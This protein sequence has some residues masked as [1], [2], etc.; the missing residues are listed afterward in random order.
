MIVS[1]KVLEGITE[2]NKKVAMARSF[3]ALRINR[4]PL[5]VDDKQFSHPPLRAV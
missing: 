4:I 3:L 5:P 2:D 1:F